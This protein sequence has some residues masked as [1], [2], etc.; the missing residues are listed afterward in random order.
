MLIVVWIRSDGDK[1]SI[2]NSGKNVS[3]PQ[4]D[5][6]SYLHL[7]DINESNESID[8]EFPDIPHKGGK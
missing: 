6:A 3:S 5:E 2:G 8:K 4:S 1:C 7:N